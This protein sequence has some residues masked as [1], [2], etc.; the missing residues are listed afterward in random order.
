MDAGAREPERSEGR[1]PG[2]RPFGYFWL[3]RHSGR[4]PKVT[5]R[6]GGT[7]SRHYRRNGY[8]LCPKK[9]APEPAPSRASL[10]PTGGRQNVT[11]RKGETVSGRDRRNGYV[12]RPKKCSVRAGIIAGNRASTRCFY[13]LCKEPRPLQRH[14]L[15]VRARPYGGLAPAGLSP[16]RTTAALSSRAALRMELAV[17][18]ASASE[19]APARKKRRVNQP[20]A[21]A[22]STSP[23]MRYLTHS[24]WGWAPRDL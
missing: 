3:G 21:N 9:A 13:K 22:R 2:A 8:V 23:S 17:R 15:I 5:R 14:C 4:L 12:P 11:R 19:L 24:S 18:I 1:T 16:G 6:K 20:W 7:L 10:A